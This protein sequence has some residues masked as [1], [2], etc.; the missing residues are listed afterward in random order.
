MWFGAVAV[1]LRSTRSAAAQKNC[2]C[3]QNLVGSAQFAVLTLQLGNPPLLWGRHA[4]T[5]AAVH[6]GLL[7]PI[8]QRFRPNPEL[9]P[10][11]GDR[12]HALAALGGRLADPAPRSPTPL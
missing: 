5:L 12:S 4:R 11:P 1:N 6:L 2:R 8:P 7:E 3:F 9:A 10:H